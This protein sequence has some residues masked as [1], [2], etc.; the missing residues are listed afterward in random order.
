MKSV[1]MCYSVPFDFFLPLFRL[2]K[3][4]LRRI[5]AATCEEDRT[6]S[7]VGRRQEEGIKGYGFWVVAQQEAATASSSEVLDRFGDLTVL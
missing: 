5:K 7:R 4:S 6:A 2:S 3:H 1:T